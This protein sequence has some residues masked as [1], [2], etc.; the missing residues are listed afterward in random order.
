MEWN[1]PLMVHA[2]AELMEGGI[3]FAFR[4]GPFHLG[5]PIADFRVDAMV[6]LVFF[7]VALA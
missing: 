2:I 1:L 3:A 7:N 5:V 6:V 4:P